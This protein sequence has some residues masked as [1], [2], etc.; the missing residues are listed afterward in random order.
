MR[1][2][3][4]LGDLADQPLAQSGQGWFE[5]AAGA[6]QP[7]LARHDVADVAAVDL[8]DADDQ[9]RLRID[10][11]ADDALHGANERAGGQ[12]RV[13]AEMRHRGVGAGAGEAKF[14]HVDGGH[15][16][17]DA[18][19]DGAERHSRPVVHGVDRLD[20]EAVEQAGVDHAR[21]AALVFLRGLE[22]E[23]HG[24]VEVGLLAQQLGGAEQGSG[25][26][27]VATG[28]HDAGIAGGVRLAG[29]LGDRQRVEF[30]AQADGAVA[31]AAAQRADDAGAGDALVHLQ[32]ERAKLLGD[33]GR[34]LVLV[35]AEFG[36]GV[37]G[38]APG[39]DLGRDGG[40]A[41][42]V[43]HVRSPALTLNLQRATL[44]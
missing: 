18:G 43:Q 20:G 33:E 6:L 13:V 37:D 31:G 41:V 21:A 1:R 26:A 4:A 8:G 19:G 10:R 35:E 36:V 3:D 24:A 42:V 44:F 15:H 14:E 9:R 38:V 25:V 22:H 34:R 2:R 16:R 29:V 40:D 5:E 12:D 27:I 11:A 30:G 39:H 17:A 32:A 23:M 7:D 28:V